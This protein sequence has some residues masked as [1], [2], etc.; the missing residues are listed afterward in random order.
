MDDNMN[1]AVTPNE[2]EETMAPAMPAEGEAV[3]PEMPAEG[4]PAA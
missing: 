4:E 3:A 2:G 1:P